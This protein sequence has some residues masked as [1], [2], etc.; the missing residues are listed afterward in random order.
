MMRHFDMKRYARER[1]KKFIHYFG[2]AIIQRG[3]LFEGGC[4]YSRKYGTNNL[5]EINSLLLL[6]QTFIEKMTSFLPLLERFCHQS[7]S[8][9]ILIKTL[10]TER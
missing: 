6:F 4:Y 9:V 2:E 8:I 5:L 7:K 1:G 3:R 10:C